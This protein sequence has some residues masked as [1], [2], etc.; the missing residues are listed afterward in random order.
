MSEYNEVKF[1]EGEQFQDFVA[2][3]LTKNG[4]SINNYSSIQ[5][6]R[7]F[8]ENK[9]GIEIKNDQIFRTTHR[10]WIEIAEKT[11]PENEEWI[12]SGIFREDNAWLYLIGDSKELYIFSKKQLRKISETFEQEVN[13][14]KTSLGFFLPVGYKGGMLELKKITC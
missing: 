9:A 13:K 10:F 4:I 8:G 11:N 3:V 2:D 1:N 5:Y 7:K 12:P 6:Q 14:N